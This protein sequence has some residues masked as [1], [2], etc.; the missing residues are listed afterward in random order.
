[1]DNQSENRSRINVSELDAPEIVFDLDGT[2][3]KGDL[4]ETVFFHILLGKSTGRKDHDFGLEGRKLIESLGGSDVL[5]KKYF[6][7]IRT[8]QHLEASKLLAKFIAKLPANEVESITRFVLRQNGPPELIEYQLKGSGT[9][10]EI[11]YGIELQN[12]LIDLMKQFRELGA[13]IWIVSASPQPIVE[14]FGSL[15]DIGSQQILAVK[16]DLETDQYPRAPYGRGKVSS[17]EGEGIERPL[18]VFGNSLGDL[19][20]LEKAQFSVVMEGSC[21][22]LLEIADYRGWMVYKKDTEFEII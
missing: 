17:L 22:A 16:V 14:V 20:M 6:S 9:T 13:R 19:E 8:R 5:L 1:M 12:E 18:I 7:L 4:G 3:V 10:L 21:E 15:I 11:R 2:L